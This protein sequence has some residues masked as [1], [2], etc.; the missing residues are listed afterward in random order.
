M[1]APQLLTKL[2][3]RHRVEDMRRPLVFCAFIISTFGGDGAE[4]HIQPV[5][6]FG[7][8]I[9]PPVRA[10]NVIVQGA[11]CSGDQGERPCPCC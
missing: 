3:P 8:S 4:D 2:Q 1:S 9:E 6:P 7:G 5:G 11:V 10:E